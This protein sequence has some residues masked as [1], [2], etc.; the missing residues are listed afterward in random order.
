MASIVVDGLVVPISIGGHPALDFCNTRAGRNG[1]RPKEYLLTHAHLAVWAG[2]TGVV[3]H[4]DVAALRRAGRA[5]P[6]GA[7]QVLARA[8]RLREALYLALTGA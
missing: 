1:P 3:P 7:E 5:D 4:P 8:L 2:H 6:V